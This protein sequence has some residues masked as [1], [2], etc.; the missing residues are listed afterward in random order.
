MNRTRRILLLLL[1]LLIA[2]AVACHHAGTAP[3][4]W[5]GEPVTAPDTTDPTNQSQG[6]GGQS[7]GTLQVV[8]CYGKLL[9]NHTALRLTTP[10]QTTLFW[11]PGG[12]YQHDDPAY[13][14]RH[15]V[16]TDNA[17][18]IDEW[19]RYRRDGCREPIMEVYRWSIDTEQAKRIH[20]IL[21]EYV[22]PTDPTQTFEP[23]AGGLQCCKRVSELLIRFAD[24][25]PAV[26]KRYFWPHELGEHL[27]GQ[28]PDD[29][30]VYRA[31][32]PTTA[33]RLG[34]VP[35]LNE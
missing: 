13:A 26:T 31:D 30:T 2:P 7:T 15:D 29:V 14:R 16:L 35:T 22:D 34:A 24:G 33:Y 20:R 5:V 25:R 28:Q 8:I 1:M 12:T 18:S 17:P 3:P 4:G 21:T 19:W 11:D 6:N 32:G 27:W 23:D 10:D 9:S